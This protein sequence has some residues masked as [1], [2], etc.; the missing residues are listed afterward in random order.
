MKITKKEFIE[1]MTANAT[2][3]V[4]MTKRLLSADEVQCAISDLFNPE[5]ILEKRTCT[6]RSN[7]IVFSG[8][9]RLYLD[10]IGKYTFHKYAY[11]QGTIYIC[12][13]AN[14][15]SDYQKAMYYFIRNF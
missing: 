9:S 1:S 12:Y 5:I 15:E 13:H 14:E 2:A 11:A 7:S 4:G 10:Q 8:G 3:F 6:A